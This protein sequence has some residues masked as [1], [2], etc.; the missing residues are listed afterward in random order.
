MKVR[1][2]LTERPQLEEEH[3]Q[4]DESNV[5]RRTILFILAIMV[6]GISL[7]YGFSRLL[8]IEDGWYYI[9]ADTS[10]TEVSCAS[11]FYFIYYIGDTKS[12]SAE[13]KALTTIYTD[14]C[15]SA[16]KNFS[17]HDDYEDCHNVKYLNDHP[18]EEV[19]VED[20]LYQA[21]EKLVKEN[22]RSVFMGPIYSYY[23]Y[24]FFS[25]NDNEA[26]TYD[27]NRNQEL[28]ASYAQLLEYLKDDSA[29]SLEVL[30]GNKVRLNVSDDYLNYCKSLNRSILFDFYWL[31]NA[32]IIDY[33][34]EC[35]TSRGY[36]HGMIS[37]IDGFGICLD[38]N[39]E[40]SYTYS[41]YDKSG[42][43]LNESVQ[44]KYQGVNAF[45]N[46]R[47]MKI[48]EN[49]HYHY[50]YEDGSS[51]SPYL[52][53]EGLN[54]SCHENMLFTGKRM[55]CRD[56]VL[57]SMNIYMNADSSA[58]DINSLISRGI[59]TVYVSGKD[60]Y[61][62]DKAAVSSINEQYSLKEIQ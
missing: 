19:V 49:E 47:N 37:S 7:T 30:G 12:N 9:D 15:Y 21:I 8:R 62:N 43:D 3:L 20:V 28:Y 13:R 25:Q 46:Y 2:R 60:V 35:I 16:Q 50:F 17:A 34:G 4:L 45:V 32:F 23:D 1:S 53:S 61:T 22:V 55:A 59:T 51:A 18:N 40:H 24:V 56:L 58:A 39:P 29:I 52:N 54:T 36:T 10:S 11:E 44:V 41:L 57:A 38:N 42:E 31:R 26:L 5:R 27:H 6:A 48:Y 14:A 33:L